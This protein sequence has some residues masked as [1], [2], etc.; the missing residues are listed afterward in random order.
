M[1]ADFDFTALETD[2]PKL[3]HLC[4]DRPKARK[5]R[6][7]RKPIVSQSPLIETVQSEYGLTSFFDAHATSAD[8][9]VSSDSRPQRVVKTPV[10]NKT[11]V[12]GYVCVLDTKILFFKQPSSL[13]V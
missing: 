3:S 7:V 9:E 8:S 1:I 11:V 6:N 13:S 10:T 2:T 12:S 5:T 4:K